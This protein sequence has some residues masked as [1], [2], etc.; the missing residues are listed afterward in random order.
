MWRNFNKEQKEGLARLIDT[1]AAT[2][3][4]SCFAAFTG[5]APLSTLHVIILTL[6]GPIL[7]YAAL[8]L[9]RNK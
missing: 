3:I 2:T 8:Y 5:Y 1:L 9:R 4:I 6:V 7:V